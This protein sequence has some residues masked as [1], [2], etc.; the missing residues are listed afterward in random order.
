VQAH[1]KVEFDEKLPSE[2]RKGFW[3]AAARGSG[4]VRNAK[5][6]DKITDEGTLG[7]YCT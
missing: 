3:G 2:I 1:R 6:D 7:V 4:Y 5:D